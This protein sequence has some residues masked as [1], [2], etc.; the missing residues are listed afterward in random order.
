MS[1]ISRLESNKEEEEGYEL[2]PQAP[3]E[4]EPIKFGFNIPYLFTE[5]IIEPWDGTCGVLCT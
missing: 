4:Q 2:N 3:N 1:L 5:N